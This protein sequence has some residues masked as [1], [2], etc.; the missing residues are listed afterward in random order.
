MLV[1]KRPVDYE[2]YGHRHVISKVAERV[3][4]RPGAEVAE[5]GNVH[6]KRNQNHYRRAEFKRFARADKT[7]RFSP[8]NPLYGSRAGCNAYAETEI[9]GNICVEQPKIV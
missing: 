7:A 8:L 3:P 9:V 1:E 6:Q 5:E 4:K 2:K